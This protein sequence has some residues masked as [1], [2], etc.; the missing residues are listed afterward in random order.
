MVILRQQV[1]VEKLRTEVDNVAA[2][3]DDGDALRFGKV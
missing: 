3:R 2:A 1:V